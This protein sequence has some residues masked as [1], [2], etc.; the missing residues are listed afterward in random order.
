M[1]AE[2]YPC[3]Y[4][5]RLPADRLRREIEEAFGDLE[6]TIDEYAVQVGFAFSKEEQVLTW[7]RA[8]AQREGLFLFDPQVDEVTAGD[9]RRLRRMSERLSRSLHAV[10]MADLMSRARAGDAAALNDLGY[11][12]YLGEGG[13]DQDIDA[14]VAYYSRAADLGSADALFNLAG[15]YRDGAGVERDVP[16]AV[17]LLEAAA[18]TDP[19]CAPYALGL[20][21]AE[22]DGVQRD[23]TRAEAL[24]RQA[25]KNGHPE[26]RWALRNK[27]GI[28]GEQP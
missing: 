28:G 10:E 25:L 20:I 11:R 7:F 13:A 9:R 16:R 23:E 3:P 15:C 22:G 2:G 18:Q 17:E 24:L 26:A 14:A 8:L 27:L 4:V 6:V 5:G 1:L 19:V 12:H 21:Y